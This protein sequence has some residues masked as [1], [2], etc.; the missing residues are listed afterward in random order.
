MQSY[1]LV[2]SADRIGEVA[3]AMAASD[4]IGLD[5][6]TTSLRPFDHDRHGK[7][8]EIRLIQVATQQGVWTVDLFQTGTLGAIRDVLDKQDRVIV[9]QNLK[10]EQAWLLY[11]YGI[12]LW[13]VFDTWRASEILYN[14]YDYMGHNLY[15]LYRRELEEEPEEGALD[16]GA[17]D[18]TGALSQK[19]YDYA[20]S[21]VMR[22]HRLREK[23]KAKLLANGLG[24]TA[25][26][27]FG[28]I[29][30]EASVEN[31]GFPLDQA[32]WLALAE[33]NQKAAREIEQ[34]LLWKLPNPKNQGALPGFAP[35]F[36]LDSP[37]Q[38]L[39]SFKKLGMTDLEDT[40]EM[41]LAMRASKYP[42]LKRFLEY[43]TISQQ[44]KSFG[45]KYI[46]N[47]HPLT[48]LIHAGY[49]PFTGAGRYSCSK[50]NL[51]QIPRL[52]MF[53]NCFRAP[54]GEIFIIADYSNIEM[55]IVAELSGDANLIKVFVDRRDAHTATAAIITGVSEAKIKEMVAA[56]SPVRQNAKPVNFGFI[57][58]MQA[59]KLVL[60]AQSEYGVT[61][62]PSEAEEFREKFFQ[63]YPGIARWHKEI[64]AYIDSCQKK[65]IQWGEV[66]TKEGRRR[67][68][69]VMKAFNEF[70]NTPSQG[71]GAGA[72]KRAL[73]AVYMR[74]K[75]YGG[76]GRWDN[77]FRVKMRHHVHD[78]C[79]LTAPS[80]TSAE[81]EEIRRGA[82]KDLEEGMKEGAQALLPRVPV[83]VEAHI[84]P[85]WADK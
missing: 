69:D 11:K 66:R 26:T 63:G 22:L 38:M 45:P 58:G 24:Q 70:K 71:T 46:K 41:T 15:D 36:N 50:P 55:R 56:G 60:Y 9:G 76:T 14:G 72:L 73:R 68:L 84:G 23:L 12:E 42:I 20:A 17:S 19:Q 79:V 4:V 13:P 75:K 53:R 10:F 51:Q 8:G 2:T 74:L 85:S 34:E 16:L 1:T 81:S 43:R 40:S 25:L 37:A 78:E 33:K 59:A 65:G 49:Y 77:P 5:I 32:A 6:E 47:I 82:Q 44:I 27:E 28:A 83:E 39:E 62:S 31:N 35:H 3:N 61:L 7:P 57:Y 52:K 80:D 29:L 21:D 48:G 54:T 18:W 30:P 64:Q 67:F